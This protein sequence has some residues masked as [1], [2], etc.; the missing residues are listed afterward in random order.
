[1][2]MEI[3]REELKLTQENINKLSF[4]IEYIQNDM[5]NMIE[6]L[7]YEEIRRD[8]LMDMLESFDMLVAI[9]DHVM[10]NYDESDD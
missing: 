2:P 7:E 5:E 8:L 6:E 10:D 1:M 3:Y 9:T 4:D